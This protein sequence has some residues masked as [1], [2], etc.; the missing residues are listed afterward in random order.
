MK[1]RDLK[2]LL[3]IIILAIYVII[4]KI[5]IIPKY[6]QYEGIILSVFMIITSFLSI[7]LL[8]YRHEKNSI[9]R[10]E[11]RF[12]II[13]QI[14]VCFFIMY[15]LGFILGF[16]NN[17]YSLSFIKIIKNIINPL[18]FIIT[19]EI[20]RN[21]VIKGNKDKK[22]IIVIIT[23][24]ILLLDMLTSI[25]S[26]NLSNFNGIFIFVTTS[27]LPLITK[28]FM[29]SYV[30]YYTSIKECLLYRIVV[31]LYIYVVP[32][33]SDLGNYLTSLIDVL[34]PY[35][36]Y[37]SINKVINRREPIEHDFKNKRF[38][39]VDVLFTAFIVF[40]VLIITGAMGIQ[41]ISIGSN[42]MSPSINKGDAVILKLKNNDFKK[43]DVISFDYR[44][45][46]TVHRIVSIENIN[47]ETIYHTKGDANNSS[48]NI[49][50]K[51]DMIKGK[52]LFRIPYI[53]YPSI[54]IKE[55]R[56]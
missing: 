26:Y 46:N 31:D 10:K 2:N 44:G 6:L 8:G 34:Y 1:K 17:A 15:G 47:G 52:V 49:E 20:I 32:I 11:I 22:S 40:L 23:I 54:W 7:I 38:D 27:L 3:L 5:L 36:I 16:Q 29:L 37:T 56:S 30:S 39:A 25:N 4:Y 55:F 50:V 45:R 28:H 9:Q 33:V 51:K 53:G 41:I 12:I 13:Y 24:L 19:S 14:I 18:I 43:N 35:I 48:D 42:S 21:V